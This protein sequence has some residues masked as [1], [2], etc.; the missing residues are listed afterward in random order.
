VLQD[1]DG[2]AAEF[3]GDLGG[4]VDV[5]DVG[6]AEVF[7]VQLDEVVA[8]VAVERGLLV[9]VVAVAQLGVER[10]GED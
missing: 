6:V 9:R 8:E 2:G 5:E 10:Q 4:G 1:G 3:Q 7:A